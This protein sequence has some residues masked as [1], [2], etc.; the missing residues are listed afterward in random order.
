MQEGE[1]HSFVARY[2]SRTVTGMTFSEV[3]DALVARGFDMTSAIATAHGVL[4][5]PHSD[6]TR[7]AAHV[8]KVVAPVEVVEKPMQVDVA[9]ALLAGESVMAGLSNGPPIQCRTCGAVHPE[10]VVCVIPVFYEVLCD[11]CGSETSYNHDG[12]HEAATPVN[13]NGFGG[14]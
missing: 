10:G 13:R 12:P 3:G 1:A 14:M 7:N 8:F 11:M 4:I 9:S 5:V 2:A 6:P